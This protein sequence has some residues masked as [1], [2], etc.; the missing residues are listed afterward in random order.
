M[1]KDIGASVRAKLLNIAR[2]RGQ[3]LDVILR[4]FVLERLLFRL[5]NSRFS[6]RFV[7]KGAMLLGT[8]L[9]GLQRTTQDLDLLGYGSGAPEEIAR[10]FREVVDIECADG[11][12]FDAAGIR[13]EHIREAQEYEGLRLRTVAMLSGA[14]IPVVVDIGFGDAVA[15]EPEDME[16]PV[17][18]N[19]PA[20]KIRAYARETVIAEKFQAM[21]VLGRANSRMK[22]FYDI[23]MLSRTCDLR[24][25]RLAQAISAT[26]ER[27][28]TEIPARRPDA[29]TEEFALDPT[30]VAQWRSFAENLAAAPP[31][32]SSI[33][34]DLADFL[35]L[36][37]REAAKNNDR[38]A[39]SGP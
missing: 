16:Y 19:F 27:R 10:I 39:K 6:G 23:W 8:W 1:A 24:R 38:K 11:V 25:E 22:D 4:T 26:F 32:L 9:P 18:L 37:V 31:E 2:Q 15:P 33:V 34:E 7:L 29:L 5:S 35:M 14:R 28:G 21:V 13:V 30:K 3:P 36:A 20:P 17:L 12:E